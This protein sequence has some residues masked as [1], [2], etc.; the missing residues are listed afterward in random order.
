MFMSE[1]IWTTK[2]SFFLQP[3]KSTCTVILFFTFQV[4]FKYFAR[5]FKLGLVLFV[6]FCRDVENSAH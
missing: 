5:V 3:L 1:L 6:C 4:C 2:I